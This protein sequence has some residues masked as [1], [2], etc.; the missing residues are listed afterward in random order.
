MQAMEKV[1]VEVNKIIKKSYKYTDLDTLEEDIT[2]V[3]TETLIESETVALLFNTK[4]Q[5]L[6]KVP[7]S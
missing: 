1:V 5:S 7:Q 4:T 6:T 3:F 2:E